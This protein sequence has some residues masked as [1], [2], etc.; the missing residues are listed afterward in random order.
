MPHVEPLALDDA[1]EKSQSILKAIVEKFGHSFNNFSTMAHQPDV[2]SGCAQVNNGIRNDLPERRRELAYFKSSQTN[3]CD[4]CSHYH[5][6][7]AE[8]AGVTDKQ[9]ASIGDFV[10]S[11]QFEDQEKT[12]L[13]YTEQLTGKSDVD[14]STVETLK[15]FLSDQ[16]LVTLAATV[17]LT[18]FTNRFNHGLG[19]ELT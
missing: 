13:S 16:Q 1:P 3:G 17:A 7:A 19:I 2:L 6:Q 10:D 11:D 9:F 15:G 8:K 4:Y 18:N 5:E 12:V 14:D